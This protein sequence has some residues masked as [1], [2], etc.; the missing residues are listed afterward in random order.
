MTSKKFSTS[1][2]NLDKS[3]P[4]KSLEEMKQARRR[5]RGNA[6]LKPIIT[7]T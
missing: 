6:F 7:L 3:P 1:S 2:K 5:A 4:E